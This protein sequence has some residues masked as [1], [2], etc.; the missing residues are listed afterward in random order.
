MQAWKSF[1]P[2]YKWPL[3]P[4]IWMNSETST[5]VPGGG[6]EV[7]VFY[8][9]ISSL[10]SNTVKPCKNRS[11][12]WLS[13]QWGRLCGSE[14]AA[15]AVSH[16]P[17]Q[18]VVPWRCLGHLLSA[19]LKRRGEVSQWFCCDDSAPAL[20]APALSGSSMQTHTSARTEQ[21]EPPERDECI[22]W[23][24]PMKELVTALPAEGL[25]NR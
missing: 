22:A 14:G 19:F 3:E 10:Q 20:A 21:Y 13:G 9:C 6:F 23:G 15:A 2:L 5:R 11:L 4:R 16:S 8:E 12:S 17:L 1:S 7:S 24:L 18:L 25:I